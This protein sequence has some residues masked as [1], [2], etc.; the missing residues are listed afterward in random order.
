MMQGSDHFSLNRE[1]VARSLRSSTELSWRDHLA[2]LV[3]TTL[4]LVLLVLLSPILIPIGVW[5]LI[6]RGLTAMKTPSLPPPPRM[7]QGYR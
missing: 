5:M 6:G 2:L 4:G 1:T 3:S 7:V